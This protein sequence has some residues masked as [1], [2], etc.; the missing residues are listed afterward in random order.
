MDAAPDDIIRGVYDTTLACP[1]VK[2]VHKVAAR[3]SGTGYWIDMHVR[4][5]PAMP[6][7]EAHA[8]VHRVTDEIR[9]AMP[10]VRDVL[11][12]VETFDPRFATERASAAAPAANVD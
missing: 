3:K 7:S 2:D 5:D 10:R 11:I 4:V 8:L 9:S 12:H 6:V 1:G